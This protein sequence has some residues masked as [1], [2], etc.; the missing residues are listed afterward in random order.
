M[1]V[2]VC[3]LVVVVVLGGGAGGVLLSLGHVLHCVVHLNQ[4]N[5]T[6]VLHMPGYLCMHVCII[7]SSICIICMS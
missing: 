7:S 2:C 1:C 3:W 4:L 6:Y 5:L